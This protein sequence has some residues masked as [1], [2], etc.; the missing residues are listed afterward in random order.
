MRMVFFT[1]TV[2]LFALLGQANFFK[3]EHMRAKYTLLALTFI[4]PPLFEFRPS[5][6]LAYT[7]LW[8]RQNPESNVLLHLQPSHPEPLPPSTLP[9]RVIFSRVLEL[10]DGTESSFLTVQCAKRFMTPCDSICERQ[11]T[12]IKYPVIHPII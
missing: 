10:P 5:D 11:R 2:P 3:G 8:V 12:T 1:S 7:L 9:I 6:P 4:R